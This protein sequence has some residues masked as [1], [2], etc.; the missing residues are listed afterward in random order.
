MTNG[1]ERLQL[2]LSALPNALDD[3]NM[4]W[5]LIEKIYFECETI[6]AEKQQHYEG[7]G[8]RESDTIK[9]YSNIHESLRDRDPAKLI[10]QQKLDPGSQSHNVLAVGP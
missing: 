9:F 8:N 4:T 6:I 7:L 5:P 10:Q 3:I 1:V 2:A